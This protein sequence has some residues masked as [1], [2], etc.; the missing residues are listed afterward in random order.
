MSVGFEQDFERELDGDLNRVPVQSL[1]TPLTLSRRVQ[2]DVMRLDRIHSQI[3]GNKWFKLKPAIQQARSTGLPILS[4]GG[5]W[6]NHIHALAFA[7]AHFSI[8]TLGIIRGEPE[9]AENSMLTDARRWGMQLHFVSRAEYRQRQDAAFQAFLLDK[10]GDALIVPEGGSQ[11]DAVAAVAEIWQHPVFNSHRYD[12]VF[13]PVGTGGTLAG[14]LS[15]APENVEVIGVPVLKADNWL[16]HDVHALLQQ[17]GAE[18]RCRWSL[19]TTA[20]GGGYARIPREISALMRVIKTAADLELDPVYTAK[21]LWALQRRI[22]QCRI[23]PHSRIL[24][25]H[26]GGLQGNRGFTEQLESM[27]SE[28]VG[29]LAL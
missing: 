18:V 21:A 9:Y 4:F 25:L 19:D 22:V 17:A 6:S 10:F 13:L 7:G 12:A 26:T 15:A 8:P 14:I 5:A 1:I 11:A 24:M 20:H 29:P 28:F 3:S 27:A 2:V 16:R 23:N